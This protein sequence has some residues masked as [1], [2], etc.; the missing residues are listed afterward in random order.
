MKSHRVYRVLGYFMWFLCAVTVIVTVI[1]LFFGGLF[2]FLF[3]VLLS[4]LCGYFAQDFLKHSERL[5]L[6]EQS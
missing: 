4:F 1:S 2:D 5:K 3:Y 6:G